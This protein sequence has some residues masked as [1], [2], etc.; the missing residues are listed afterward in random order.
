MVQNNSM[1]GI[2]KVMMDDA[3]VHLGT[4]GISVAQQAHIIR[5]T[6]KSAK[7]IDEVARE[8]SN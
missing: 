8:K 7:E 2:C 1:D 3:W 6:P 5:W 4:K